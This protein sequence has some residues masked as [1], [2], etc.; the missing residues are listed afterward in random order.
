MGALRK[1]EY[2]GGLIS[3]FRAETLKIRRTWI[4]WLH[5][6]M[7][8]MGILIFFLY[9]QVSGVKN[10]NTF[11]SYVEVLGVACPALVGILC[12]LTAEQER[13]AGK[14]Q[15]LLGIGMSRAENLAVKLLHL[16]IWN[17]AAMALAVL[18][19]GMGYFGVLGGMWKPWYVY[20]GVLLLLWLPQIFAYCFHLFLALQFGGGISIGTGVAESLVG[21]LL[22]T[23][24]GDGIWPFVPCAWASRLTGL[25]LY[26]CRISTEGA[27]S[28][29]KTAAVAGMRGMDGTS[30]VWTAAD[31]EMEELARKMT[32]MVGG[33]LRVGLVC[34]AGITV[35]G[36]VLFFLWFHF[37]EGGKAE[38]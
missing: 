22:L 14:F 27:D 24:L 38:E 34:A 6:V 31:A 21:A 28:I 19:F 2:R 26:L 8:V 1:L 35:V 13:N 17:L 37:F 4:L 32:D 23:G 33:Q 25:C 20:A 16:L 11:T 12:G 18:G 9:Y 29:A 7:P 3:R 5:I 36:L 30:D 10:W 15:N